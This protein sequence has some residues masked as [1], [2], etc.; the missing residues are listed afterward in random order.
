[1]LSRHLKHCNWKNLFF[2]KFILTGGSPPKF[3]FK[4]EQAHLDQS[5]DYEHLTHSITDVFRFAN[6]QKDAF[7]LNIAINFKEIFEIEASS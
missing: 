4:T 3:R 2:A 7:V 6:F 1:M 5:E